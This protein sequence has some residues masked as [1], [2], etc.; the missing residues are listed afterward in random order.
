[1]RKKRKIKCKKML[2]ILWGC[3]SLNLHSRHQM[4]LP[5]MFSEMNLAK[6]KQDV[7]MDES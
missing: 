6:T 2:K 5:Q 7:M 1:M 3:V 4:E